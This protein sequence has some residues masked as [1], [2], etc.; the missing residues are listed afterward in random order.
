MYMIPSVDRYN[1][2]GEPRRPQKRP[3]FWE[4]GFVFYSAAFLAGVMLTL[5]LGMTATSGMLDAERNK[6][7]RIG[8]CEEA[9]ATKEME[10][11]KL[12]GDGECWCKTPYQ[13][14]TRTTTAASL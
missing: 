14:V 1:P 5:A 4:G 3:P 2:E 6:G 7:R 8:H 11:I 9:C 12:G 13:E 10:F